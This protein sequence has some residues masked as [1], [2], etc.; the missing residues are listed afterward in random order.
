M[1]RFALLQQRPPVPLF[2]NAP[3]GNMASFDDLFAAQGGYPETDMPLYDDYTFPAADGTVAPEELIS[4]PSSA[5]FTPESSLFESP[6]DSPAMFS[7][8]L[9]T[10]PLIDGGLDS[11]LDEDYSMMAPLFPQNSFDQYA[12]MPVPLEASNQP[13]GFATVNSRSVS[14]TS[15]DMQRQRSTGM[16]RQ[17]SSPGRPPNQPYHNRKRSDTVG[18]SKAAKAR[19]PL[20]EIPIEEGDPKEIAKRKKNTLAARKSRQRKQEYAEQAEAEIQ[21]L[22]AIVSSLGGDHLLDPPEDDE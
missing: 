5:T 13:T 22:R 6:F 21:R 17:K 15:T 11:T 18:I 3:Q 19:K 8:G 20:P 10:T 4:A 16:E 14:M 2:D 9:N 7:S 12:T 1:R